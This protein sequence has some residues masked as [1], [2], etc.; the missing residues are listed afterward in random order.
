M[1]LFHDQTKKT[2]GTSG[3]TL[4]NLMVGGAISIFVLGAVIST[5][6][7]GLKMVEKVELKTGGDVQSKIDRFRS[8]IHRSSKTEVGFQYSSRFRGISFGRL[9]VGNAVQITP[10]ED[11]ST[12]VCYYMDWRSKELRR[13]SSD[14]PKQ[15]QVVFRDVKSSRPFTAEDFSGNILTN[16]QVRKVIAMNL[17]LGS[18]DDGRVKVGGRYLFKEFKL[19]AMAS[20]NAD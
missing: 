18:V 12:T 14:N 9:R 5:H 1:K 17:E 15:A 16:A 19:S 13:V 11:P 4:V 2:K 8:D 6:F 7:F 20:P 3:F 10:L